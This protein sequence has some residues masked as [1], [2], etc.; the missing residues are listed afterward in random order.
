[1]SM[2]PDHENLTRKFKFYTKEGIKYHAVF[3]SFKNSE[4]RAL[5]CTTEGHVQSKQGQERCHAT[6]RPPG[7]SSRLQLLHEDD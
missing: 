6:S 1:M 2:R 3:S 4:E 5:L 7:K